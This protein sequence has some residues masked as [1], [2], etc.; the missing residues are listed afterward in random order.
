MDK[1]ITFYK[2]IFFII[3]YKYFP[4]FFI[5]LSTSFVIL[6]IFRKHIIFQRKF[7]LTALAIVLNLLIIPIGIYLSPISHDISSC[8]VN[9]GKYIIEKDKDTLTKMFMDNQSLSYSTY[10]DIIDDSVDVT[11][12]YRSLT[13]MI[14]MRIDKKIYEVVF[15]GNRLWIDTYNWSKIEVKLAT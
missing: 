7:L 9:Y 13:L 8:D 6:F 3:P 12:H 4:Y 2:N 14:F 15:S 5:T 11:Y 10:C 1:T